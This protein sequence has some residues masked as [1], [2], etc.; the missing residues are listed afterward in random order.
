MGMVLGVKKFNK[1]NGLWNAK[2]VNI[3]NI[4]NTYKLYDQIISF[5]L[6]RY[7]EII[8][9]EFDENPDGD[10][11][12]YTDL[13]SDRYSV[14]NFINYLKNNLIVLENVAFVENE[15]FDMHCGEYKSENDF[16]DAIL[17]H[18]NHLKKFI[19]HYHDTFSEEEKEEG[20]RLIMI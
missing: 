18:L 3:A 20:Y 5:I 12:S 16:R 7:N 6:D 9:F 11:C 17:N 13:S 10:E 15:F 8:V 14:I 1:K 2:Y 19:N 4:S